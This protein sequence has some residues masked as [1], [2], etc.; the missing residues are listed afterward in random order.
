MLILI[1]RLDTHPFL[2]SPHQSRQGAVQAGVLDLLAVLHEVDLHPRWMPHTMGVG[3]RKGCTRARLGLTKLWIEVEVDC[4]WPVSDRR[5]SLVVDGVDC[6]DGEPGRLRQIVV[7]MR[8]VDTAEDVVRAVDGARLP[9]GYAT[10]P[11]G[12]APTTDDGCVL[13]GVELGGFILTPA[14]LNPQLGLPP[15]GTLVQLAARIDPRMRA[16]PACA[17]NI[18]IKHLAHHILEAMSDMATRVAEDEEY[19]RACARTPEF[20]DFIRGRLDEALA[21]EASAPGGVE[22]EDKP[23]HA[24]T[25]EV[26]VAAMAANE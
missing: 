24:A 16:L 7:L 20:Y 12:A 14:E 5:A 8:S 19:Q 2:L 26:G 21:E 22:G 25:A 6:L 13:A 9:E 18:G 15:R 3:V 17:I 4:P 23:G 11:E 1:P 10:L